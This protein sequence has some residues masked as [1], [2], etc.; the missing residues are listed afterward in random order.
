LM[1]RNDS[2]RS[3]RFQLTAFA[4]DQD[5]QGE[6]KLQPTQDIVFF[7]ALLSLAPKQE[8]NIRIGTTAGVGATEKTYRLYVEELPPLEA[9]QS[10]KPMVAIRTKTGIPI[11]LQ[12][13]KLLHSG[14]LNALQVKSGAFTFQIQNTGNVHFVPKTVRVRALDAAGNVVLEKEQ[15]GWYILAGGH[16]NYELPIPPGDCAKVAT[17]DVEVQTNAKLGFTERLSVPASAC[18]S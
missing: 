2:D 12:P 4:W 6:L 5:G 17:L 1:L 14:R 9:M 13:P 16:R 11:F 7:P 8:R 10:D 3:V 18:S 15:S